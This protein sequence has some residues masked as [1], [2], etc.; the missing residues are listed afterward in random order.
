[1]LDNVLFGRIGHQHADGAENIRDIVRGVLD[2]L[3][4]SDDVV[5]IGLEFNV[6]VGGQR[7]TAAQRQKLHVA[8]ALLK[9][10]DFIIFNKPLS[11]LDAAS[12]EQIDPRGAR[13]GPASG[14]QA[15]HH[16]GAEQP[17]SGAAVRPRRGARPRH[18]VEDGKYDDSGARRRAFSRLWCRR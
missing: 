14:S 7:L 11:A 5:K 6:G 18:G 17:A 12:Q 16:L 2:E 8:R 4:L 15:G 1:M 10:A 9:R 3:T 13:G